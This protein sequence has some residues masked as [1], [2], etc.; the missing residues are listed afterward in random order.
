MRI[1][2][3]IELAKTF[4]HTH[5]A[6]TDH[7]N[8]HGAI[9]FYFKAREAGITP[10]LGCEI[11]V[12][13]HEKGERVHQLIVLAQNT[14]GYKHLLKIVSSAYIGE[15]F[16]GGL[17]I[18]PWDVLKTYAEH[19][20]TFSSFHN[21]EFSYL[22]KQIKA[23]CPDLTQLDADSR[24]LALLRSY[25]ENLQHS[26]G[27]DNVYVEITDNDLP[28][29]KQEMQA[30]AYIARLLKIPLV[31]SANAHYLTRD[32][33]DTHALAVA[34]KNSLT[35]KD[36]DKRLRNTQL[37]L[38]DHEEMNERF[39]DYPEALANTLIIAQRCSHVKIET[40]HYYFP[41][42]TLDNNDE[43]TATAI[44][45]LSAEGLKK[46]LDDL[47]PLYGDSFTEEAQKPYWDRLAYELDVIV[48][49]G[50]VDYFLIVQDFIRW[51]KEQGI[52]V[53]P[54]RGSGAGSL[55]AYSLLITDLDPLK[56][57]LI[58][59]RFLNPERISMPDFDI[60]FCQW[61]R[62]EVIQYCIQKYGKNNVAQITTFGKM[63]AKGAVKGVGRAK[64]LGFNRVDQ[65]T[66]LFPNDLGLT[67]QSALDQEPRLKEEM[68]K[69]DELRECMEQAMKLE[70]LC[71][72]TSVHAAGIVMSD[73]DMTDYVPIYTTD[74]SSYI[75]QYEMKLTEK[76][77]LV[78]FDF[79]GLKTLT[80]I[81][82]AVHWIHQQV[83]TKFDI[84]K[85]PLDESKVF[86][87][88]SQGHTIGVFQCESPGITQ[89]IRKLRPSAFEDVVALVALYRPGPLG[90]GMVEDFVK[91][92]HGQQKITYLLP[93][94]EPVLK[95]TYGMILYQD[96]VL[97]I[98]AV[99]AR[100][101]LGEADLLR[102]AM[103]KKI[104]EEMDR[105]KARFLS[106]ARDNGI[107]EGKAEQI[108]DLMAEFAK[109]G[110]NKAHSTAYGLI[111]YQTAY[112]KTFFP[113]CYLAACMTCD[114]DNTDKL[115]RYAEDCKR[116]NIELLT[117]D[118]NRSH[119]E[120][121]PKK[122]QIDFALSGIKGLGAGP[123]RPL[124]EERDKNGLFTSLTDLA[125]R[126][127]L[128]RFGK[129]NLQLLV[130]SGA[131]DCFSYKRKVLD[132]LVNQLVEYSIGQHEA[133]SSGQRG[134]FDLGSESH[135]RNQEDWF[136]ENKFPKLKVGESS[137]ALRDL[138]IEKKLLGTF[139]TKHPLKLF[140]SDAKHFGN[141]K[142]ADFDRL[143][144]QN[145]KVK[146][147]VFALMSKIE[148]RR[149]KRGS[150]MAYVRLEQEDH[151]HEGV[152]FQSA[153][154]G[155]KIPE[156]HSFVLAE[157]TLEKMNPEMPMRFNIEKLTDIQ[158][159]RRSKLRS[160]SL[161]FN[162]DNAS[163]PQD[164]L[165]F[166]HLIEQFP[167]T[168]PLRFYLKNKNVHI[169]FDTPPDWKVSPCNEF[170]GR[171]AQVAS[172]HVEFSI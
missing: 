74:G 171:A 58:F 172:L 82:K 108:F 45:R 64:G 47:K 155:V 128:G 121:H 157:G 51:S 153:L 56:Y 126:V 57:D 141:V 14:K 105:Q 22:V 167:G 101:S 165:A 1:P 129:K 159:L 35:L 63:N 150:L 98:A 154:E 21:G 123:L 143:I 130:A 79:L 162:M 139:V 49:T 41:K 151:A 36:I 23:I 116:F 62:E 114:M 96:Q 90:S 80:V 18:V 24:E 83:D 169:K 93:E 72:H 91:N 66:K 48:K 110:F 95:E 38:M 9:E 65:F 97:R 145:G 10:I 3:M 113:E 67:L 133:S 142:L 37:H 78:K 84:S 44:R 111:S 46:R 40:G 160:L 158:E 25:I 32:F 144:E 147:H 55:V 8:M 170:L 118:I 11:Y 81:D 17:P 13:S 15:G 5:L 149:S 7:S 87:L 70:G 106:G 20:I 92:K 135:T 54:G 102:K 117:P 148:N 119:L 86:H 89:L 168:T 100:Y 164:I 29:Q 76:V 125:K 134:L 28:H 103:G 26:F 124:I 77:G 112:L 31:A 27:T 166:K 71:S 43:S 50:F 109:Y 69:D 120:F 85:I 107:P 122:G 42:I 60:D 39:A 73:G 53:G 68:N 161:H 16:K 34:M 33:A 146:V 4:G 127:H 137:W 163:G 156:I 59:E 94:L 140:P 6:L 12:R 131:M 19:L 138:F 132:E 115:V 136:H 2:A 99:L 88:I 61:R 52:P 30:V 75:T 104:S 152:M